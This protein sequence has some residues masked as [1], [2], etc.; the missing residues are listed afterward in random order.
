SWQQFFNTEDRAEVE[1]R[2]RA[3]RVEWE[4]T[5]E[6]GLKTRQIRPA[7]AR[8]PQTGDRIWF[9]QLL[10]HHV[11]CL[12][13]HIQ[14]SLIDTW[15]VDNLPRHAFYGDGSPIA[16]EDIAAIQSAYDHA[17]TA[18]PWQQGDVLMI[19]NMLAAHSRNP[20]KPPRKILVAMGDMHTAAQPEEDS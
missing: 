8:H 2:C 3:D 11:A 17:Q 10:L 7:I 18:F 1:T 14:Q 9:N 13:N 19:D 20:F 4:W 5:N 16:P 6:G 15:G 12:D